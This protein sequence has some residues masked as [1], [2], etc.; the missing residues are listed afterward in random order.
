VR[1]TTHIS[2]DADTKTFSLYAGNSLYAF[3]I[4]PEL[5]LEHLYWG[6]RL[7]EGFDLR[8]LDC[9]AK[10][11][12]FTTFQ[13]I[14]S[15]PK[16]TAGDA[17]LEAPVA[18]RVEDL[19]DTYMSLEDLNE[20]WKKNK[21]L[22]ESSSEDYKMLHHRRMEN[23]V[24]R[25]MRLKKQNVDNPSTQY[26]DIVEST[27][28]F[29]FSKMDTSD[30]TSHIHPSVSVSDLQSIL[31]KTNSYQIF[32]RGTDEIARG[33]VHSEFS[34]NGTGD[35]RSPSFVVECDNGSTI[36]PLRY[37]KHEIYNGN[38]PMP[39]Y[40]PHI[41]LGH[42]DCSTLIVYMRD[43][44]SGL[45]VQLIY[46]SIHNL[47]AIIRRV[48]FKNISKKGIKI[49]HQANSLTI[50]LPAIIEDYHLVHLTGSWARERHQTETKIVQGKH[51]VG[52]TRGV[53]SHEHNPYIGMSLNKF[54]LHM[55]INLYHCW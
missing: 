33:M 35:F 6:H 16:I 37:Y 32:N 47:N 30:I 42:D 54:V 20:S 31:P 49:I 38:L 34:D 17:A 36:T 5:G 52:S 15:V 24:W 21:L 25:L 9:N 43:A 27:Q 18:D 55:F 11:A 23:L 51:I 12:P 8:Y 29:N 14:T 10:V 3:A 13:H 26:T 28:P 45:E 50:D 2:F 1:A 19:L 53:S 46:V 40:F 41:R 44:F 48:I 7:H 22:V 39:E 4:S